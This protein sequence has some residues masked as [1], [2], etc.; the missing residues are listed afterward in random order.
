MEIHQVLVGASPG[1]AIT[2]AALDLRTL[3]RQVGRSEVYVRFFDHRLD[4]DV[5]PLKDFSAKPASHPEDNVI[6]FHASIGEPEVFDFLRERPERIVVVHHNISPSAPFMAYDPVFA[7]RLEGGRRELAA[8]A[9]RAEMALADSEFNADDL[10]SLGYRNVRVS[11]L[12]LDIDRMLAVEP[13]PLTVNHFD[14]MVKGPLVLFVGQL[15]PHKR[16][17]FLLEAYHALTT[18]IDP[19]AHLAI[20]GAPRL[21]R[22][23]SALEL[24]LAELH[25]PK[26]W[27]TGRVSDQ[28]LAAY[29]RRADLFVTA[30]EHEG[31]CAPLLEAMAFDVPVL[32]RA[33]AAVPETMGDAGLVLPADDGPLVMAEAMAELLGNDALRA[34]MIDRG[35]ARVAHFAP[36][37]ARATMLSHLTELF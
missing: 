31:F 23:T 18:Y 6:V 35:R 19:D 13:H 11:P 15:L 5:L 1:D 9:R 28:E 4:G 24:L 26:A 36:D 27:I 7:G 14:T 37:K 22:Y 34:A 20:V 17:D 3:L 12:V 16:P 21:P 32:A 10:R 30:T 33:F 8:L 25:L 29:Y 2:N